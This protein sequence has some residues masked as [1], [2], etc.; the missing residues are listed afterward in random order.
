MPL[1]DTVLVN[2]SR[3]NVPWRALSSRRAL[4]TGLVAMMPRHSAA[5]GDKTETEAMQCRSQEQNSSHGEQ[6]KLVFKLAQAGTK[7]H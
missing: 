6:A 3:A 1:M 4:I 7:E 5:R 2:R